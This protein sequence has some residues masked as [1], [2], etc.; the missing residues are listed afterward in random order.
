MFPNNLV[1]KIVAL[2]CAQNF[3]AYYAS[4]KNVC[5]CIGLVPSYRLYSSKTVLW[6]NLPLC[7]FEN[8]EVSNVSFAS[9]FFE[10]RCPTRKPRTVE[11][12][13]P[14]PWEQGC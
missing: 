6:P 8:T 14:T 7:Q 11:P 10:I 4:R 12:E 13:L 1:F 3:F 2:W 5:W 9:N